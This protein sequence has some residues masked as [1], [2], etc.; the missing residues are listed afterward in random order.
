MS[1]SNNSKLFQEWVIKA[2]NDLKS[3]Q[4]L[5]KERGPSDTLCFHCHQAVEKYLKGFLVFHRKRFPKTHDLIFLMNL[6]K[7][8]NEDFQEIENDL[9]TLNKYYIESRYPSEIKVYSREECKKILEITEN[10]IKFIIKKIE[11]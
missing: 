10:L 6:C 11:I 2:E 8:I 5:Y 1:A 4:I 7:K 3:A 9:I